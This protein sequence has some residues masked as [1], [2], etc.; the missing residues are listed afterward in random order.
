M[1][2]LFQVSAADVAFTTDDY[3]TPPWLFGATGLLFDVDVSAPVDPDRRTCP[4][5]RYLTLI[6]DGLAQPW[7]GLA[8]MNPPFSNTRPWVERF[9]AHPSG[10]AL[11]PALQRTWMQPLLRCADAVTLIS[12]KFGRPDGRRGDIMPMLILVARGEVSTVALARVA[13]ADKYAGG[14][15]H[16]RPCLNNGCLKPGG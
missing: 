3:Y 9:A 8:W 2:T 7:D 15:Y 16:V 11:L 12:P 1:D 6:E 13:A 5:V 4:A 10:L 14:A